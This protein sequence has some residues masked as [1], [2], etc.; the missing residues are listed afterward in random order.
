MSEVVRRSG[1]DGGRVGGRLA[2]TRLPWVTA[3][4]AAAA[5]AAN[6]LLY[7]AESAAG[8]ISPSVALPSMVGRGPVSYASVILTS[9]VVTV[10]AAIALA[11]IGLLSRRPVRV[12]W[13]VSA[14]GAALS[15]AMPVTVP[16]PAAAMRLGLAAMHPG[17]VGRQ[18]DRPDP[19]GEPALLVRTRWGPEGGPQPLPATADPFVTPLPP[20]L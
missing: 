19:A 9:I 12:F 13:F 6:A 14:A 16:G 4:A 7:A 1:S 18:R 17:R 8:V 3:L 20:P 11:V 15:L 5:A 2:W 10:W